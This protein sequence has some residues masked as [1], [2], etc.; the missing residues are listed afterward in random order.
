MKEVIDGGPSCVES[1]GKYYDAVCFGG[2][3]VHL[4][5]V[6]ILLGH[7]VVGGGVHVEIALQSIEIAPP[8]LESLG[9]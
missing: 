3:E 2:V 9:G 1:R 7:L 4:N 6:V 5:F 8:A